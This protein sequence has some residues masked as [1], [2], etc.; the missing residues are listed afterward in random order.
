MRVHVWMGCVV[1][2]M[3][4][5]G[6]GWMDQS[7]KPEA[8]AGIKA[9]GE[10]LSLVDSGNYTG[11][12]DHAAAFFRAAVPCDQWASSMTAFRAPMGSNLSRKVKTARLAT[13]LP[14]APDGHY[15]LIQYDSAFENKKSA[16]ETAT[17]MLETNGEWRVSGYFIR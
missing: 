16:V 12:W 1:V 2:A 7:D 9:A 14:G 10:W 5:V 17:M 4:V 13:T 6:C 15:V 11:S 3:L 8:Q